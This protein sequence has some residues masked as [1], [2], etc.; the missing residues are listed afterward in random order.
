MAMFEILLT[1]CF[2]AG[3]G[4]CRTQA[5][6]G[7]ETLA[8]CRAAARQGVAG[9]NP[10]LQVQ[11]FPCVPADDA[12]D[13]TASEVAPG[14]FVHKG[15]HGIPTFENGGDLT[16]L[17]FIVGSEAVA[18]I[19]TGSSRLIGEALLAAIRRETDLPIRYV[20]LTHMHPDHVLG[21]S[22]FLGEGA[23]IVSHANLGPALENRAETYLTAMTRL[24]GAAADGTVVTLPTRTVS[25]EITL[26]LGPGRDLRL[27][28][29]KTAHTDNDLTVLDTATGTFFVGDLDFHGHIPALDGSITGWLALLETLSKADARFVVPGHGPVML[30]ADR[31]FAPTQAYL[32]QIASETRAAIAAGTPMLD[33]I[34]QVGEGSRADWLL[35]DEFNPRNATAAF[36]ELEW[37]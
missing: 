28:P 8:D 21:T 5:L 7:G 4:E 24:M 10:L 31:A 17:G 30:P 22:G 16:N 37:E 12:P 33:A 29:H 32:K 6:P 26:S 27:T 3:V 2:M 34:R 1:A 13:F 14:V 25:E 18:V 15:A 20:I 11:A 9:F 36:K 35:F 19:D 23:E